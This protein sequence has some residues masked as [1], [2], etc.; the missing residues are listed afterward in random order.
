MSLSHVVFTIGDAFLI[1]GFVAAALGGLGRIEGAI[2]GGFLFGI[3]EQFVA[4]Y[5]SSLYSPIISFTLLLL[6]I[7]FRPLGILGERSSTKV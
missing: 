3:I 6:I 7:I 2:L 4:G 1:K 5:I